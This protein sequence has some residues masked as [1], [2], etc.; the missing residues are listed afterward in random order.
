MDAVL[1]GVTPLTDYRLELRLQSG[2]TAV[3]NMR[4]RVRTLRFS[5]IEE[6][7]TFTTARVEGDKVVREYGVTTFGVYGGVLDAMMM[8]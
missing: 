2:S 6:P 3:V 4:G 7:E 1:T 5:L 8:D